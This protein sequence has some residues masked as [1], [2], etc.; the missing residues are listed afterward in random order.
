VRPG[1]P[2]GW[3]Q[4]AARR[5]RGLSRDAR[6]CLAMWFPQSR[7][8]RPELSQEKLYELELFGREVLLIA[9][10]TAEGERVE[11]RR[12]WV[13][14]EELDAWIVWKDAETMWREGRLYLVTLIG[15]IA[16]VM[17]ALFALVAVVQAWRH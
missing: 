9:R 11:L 3:D 5:A 17:A 15:A 7:P 13:T 4:P 2:E 1:W 12:Q 14:R 10:T 6:T 8:R 16:A